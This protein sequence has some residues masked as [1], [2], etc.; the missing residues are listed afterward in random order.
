MGIDFRE[1]PARG[2]ASRRRPAHLPQPERR[3]RGRHPGP[4]GQG[5]HRAHH[6]RAR[7]RGPDRRPGQRRRPAPAPCAAS[8]TTSS[9]SRDPG[10]RHR[11]RARR[12][13]HGHLRR[14]PAG[15]GGRGASPG[16]CRSPARACCRWCPASSATSP[17]S[18]VSRSPRSRRG[19]MV[20]GALLFVVGFT[21]VFVLGSIFVTTAGR[22]PHRAPHAAH[23]PGWA[24]S[25]SLMGLVFLGIGQPARGEDRAGAR[26][27]GLAG[28]PVLGAVFALGWAPCTGP[29][30][31]AVLVAGQHQRGPPGLARRRA[32]RGLRPRAGPAL[33]PHRGRARPGRARVGL[34]APPPAH[35]SRSSAA[36]CSCWSALLMVTGVWQDHEHLAA[37]RAR[38]RLPVVS[39]VSARTEVAQPRLGP[40]GWLRWTWRQLTSMRTALFLLL[41][42]AI[43]AIPGSTFPQRSIDPVAHHGLDR[44]PPD[45]RAG[46]R[47]ARLLRGLRLAVVRRDLPAALRLAHRLRAAAHED[48]LAP[49]A[50][51]PAARPAPPRPA[52]RP[53]RG[54]PSTARP[55][56]CASGCAS[57]LRKRRYRVHAHD[58]E[59]LSAEKGYLRETGNL[60]FHVALIGVLVGV[61]V[62]PPARLE[63]RRHRAGG[64]DL[65]QHAVAL[66]HLQPR[67]VGRRQRPRPRTRSRSTGSTPTFETE[68]KSPGQFGAPRDFEA[69]TTFTDADGEERAAQHPGQPPARDRRRLGV[70]ARQRLRPGHHRARR[71][72]HRALLRRH[73]VPAAGQQLHLGRRG[74]GARR[75]AEA[76]RLRRVLPADRR[77]STT[78]ARTRSSPTPSTRS[79]RSPPSRA[80]CS[81]A[82]ARSRSTRSTPP[83]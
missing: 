58:D 21:A 29:T 22:A 8:S 39:A 3:G 50:L 26:A 83:R 15:G 43:G 78:R 72:G 14:A 63:G 49:G 19:R 46:A 65:R 55:T 12:G 67:A 13:R 47:P 57:A 74:Q 59:T 52:R 30:L 48:P 69:F 27:A 35:A 9:P 11:G 16:W 45:R 42:L 17:A 5:T 76:A 80:T 51:G 23:A 41:L 66:R 71:R 56:R 33:H 54:R 32:R 62:G 77:R 7:H 64:Q 60:V 40:L 1:D 2:A 70:P 82:A 6:A 28:A 61:A 34:A 37:D 73:A 25:S 36:S 31:A 38:Q 4:A 24:W 53:P 44:R 18:P 68:A 79:W 75:L 20:T 81:P 10:R